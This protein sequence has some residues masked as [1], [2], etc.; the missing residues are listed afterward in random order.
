MRELIRAF[1]S[2]AW[3]LSLLGM[4]QFNDL[5][6]PGKA[7]VGTPGATGSLSPS[8]D[9]LSNEQTQHDRKNSQISRLVVM[10]EGLASGMGNFAMSSETQ[11]S[12]FGALM[13][14]QMQ[15]NF[16]QRLLEPPGI[17]NLPGFARVPVLLPAPMQTTVITELPPQPTCN[18]SVPGLRLRDAVEMR[19]RLPLIH[20]EDARQTAVNMNWGLP[21]ISR[22]QEFMPTQVEYAV[23]CSP[24]LTIIEL[25]Y[26]EAVEAAVNNDPAS[27]PDPD[28]FIAQYDSM[29]TRLQKNDS[30]VLV[31]SIPDPLD[32]AHFFSLQDAAKILKVDAAFLRSRYLLSAD[33]VLTL[34]GVSEIGYQLF[35]RASDVL[36]PRAV[37]SPATPVAVS[38][39]VTEVNGRL[40]ELA[41]NQGCLAFDLNEIFRKMTAQ[42]YQVGT[43][44]LNG[45]Y[46]GGFYLLNGYYPGAT[47]HA[48]VANEVLALLN[49][50]YGTVF[51][52]LDVSKIMSTDPAAAYRQAGGEN[53]PLPQLENVVARNKSAPVPPKGSSPNRTIPR[54]GDWTP[55]V[56]QETAL[57]L[58][59]PPGLEQSLPLS[60]AASYFG[61]GI[62]PVHCRDEKGI[63]WGT[64]GNTLFGGLAMVDS[65]LS[66]SIRIQFSPPVNDQS[67]FHISFEGGFV[68]EDGELAAPQFFRMPFKQNRVDE[69]PGT[70]SSGILNLANGEVSDLTVYARYSSTALLALVG[71]NPTFPKQ[72]LSFPG[73]YGSVSAKF[74]QRADGKLDFT[75]YG[76][77]FVPLGKDIVWPLNFVGP[78]GQFATIPAA[79]TVM[80]P[81]LAL[82]TREPETDT[83]SVCPEVPF[84]SVQEFTLFSHNSAFG[85]LFSLNQ[86]PL[87]GPA[88]GRSHLLGR[89]QVQFGPKSGNTVPLAVWALPPGGI[90]APLSESPITQL[91]PGKLSPGPQGFNENLRFPLR[92]YPLDDLAI[93]DDPFEVS[94][95]A[96]DLDTGKFVTDL[97]HRAFISQDLIFALMR[98]EP[99]TPKDSFFFRGP[100]SFTHGANG[101][102]VFRFRGITHLPYP[103]G[104]AFPNP[105]FATGFT[106]G[107]D[108]ALDPYLW[109]HAIANPEQHGTLE[110]TA[111]HIT[112]SSGDDVSLGYALSSDS[113]SGNAFFEYENHTQS[114]KFLLHSLAWIDFCDSGTSLQDMST[115]D[116]VSF[117]GFGVWSKDGVETIQQVAVQICTS[118]QKPYVAIQ[119]GNGDI[120]NI[121]TKPKNEQVAFP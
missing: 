57:P 76:S 4:K 58:R 100:A 111:Q 59:L 46:L 121:N 96:I 52:S 35:A 17:G 94:I 110:G 43:K 28:E 99:R 72:P 90:M 48:I 24:A 7:G 92:T 112:A 74:E 86:T 117:S 113:S 84:N 15:L 56:P 14:E 83:E 18:L 31:F 87:G 3:V 108:S 49:Q 80:H 16:P 115:C 25:G 6:Q 8:R 13:A 50:H 75:F 47:G 104:F 5:I 36:P 34:A 118:A 109:F 101:Q 42:G 33:S 114:G 27:L 32:T 77:T 64:S 93:I 66:G 105:D 9:C 38:Q 26:Y 37:L 30:D 62:S 98:V 21:S 11:G 67:R 40:R 107:P 79:G 63:Q 22:G 51:P 44:T 12:C 71:V 88:K 23:Q 55:L 85:D 45:E 53:W 73:Q 39:W 119:V 116:T 82:S 103:E 120:S 91:F 95:G 61:D 78:N 89:L 20:R 19:P 106:A 70:V 41:R 10:G 97:M 81:H 60:T 69:V 68:G 102:K 2:F 54:R 65:H 29:I 1:L